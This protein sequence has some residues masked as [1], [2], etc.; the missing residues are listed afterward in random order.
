M[1]CIIFGD[2]STLPGMINILGEY[3]RL[4]VVASNRPQ[5]INYLSRDQRLNQKL[6]VQPAKKAKGYDKFLIRL[7]E[8]VPDYFFC[9]SYSLLLGK[10]LLDIPLSG[11]INFH[12]GLLPKFRG[13]NIYNWVLIEGVEESGMTAHFMSEGIDDGDIILQ[14][15]V[16]ILETDTAK[17]LKYKIDA[18]GFDL[19]ERIKY[20][21]EKGKGLPRTPQDQ[22]KSGYYR[23]RRPE[24]GLIEWTKSDREIFNLIRALVTPW[25]GA[26]YYTKSGQRVILSEYQTI[27]DIKRIRKENG[28]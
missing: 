9:F 28:F 5:A 8:E 20:L 24:D 16:R 3:V 22:S 1:R 17:T 27:E 10:E 11:A 23:R 26:F 13:A 12:G 15:K 19:L 6:C 7:R 14:E 25:P 4:A 18:L 21:I 2:E